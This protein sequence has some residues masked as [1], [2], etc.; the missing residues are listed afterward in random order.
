MDGFYDYNQIEILPSQQ[1]KTTFI[2][3]W[4]TLSYCKLP[5]DLNNVGTKFQRAMSYAFHEIKNVVETYLDN[6]PTHSKQQDIHVD[7]LRFLFL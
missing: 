6:L 1:H 2:F 5:F 7:H 3:S 4:G